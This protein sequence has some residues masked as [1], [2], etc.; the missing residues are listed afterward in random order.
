MRRWVMAVLGLGLAGALAYEAM[1]RSAR[2]PEPAVEHAQP[3]HT[4]AAPI[5]VAPRRGETTPAA[6]PAARPLPAE[7]EPDVAARWASI[8]AMV[9]DGDVAELPKLC[10]AD[11][12]KEPD[13]APAIIH[14][15][16]SLAVQG[17]DADRSLAGKTLSRW[18]REER[19]RDARDAVGNV[20]NIVEALGD[21]GGDEAVTSLVDVLE[22]EED[23]ALQ[24]TAA[25]RLAT[26]G[27]KRA[28][29]AVTRFAERLAR[30]AEPSDAFERELRAEAIK[31][32][33]DAMARLKKESN[34]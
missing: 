19:T 32:A 9:R 29:P 23:L 33:A 28:L 1:P 24:T 14:G 7:L 17:R 8:E 15:V 12:A 21:L 18:L 25:D 27:D 13:A 5:V 20:V 30:A 2:A 10:A 26:L 11:L 16:A 4:S 6:K 3:V 34:E 31:T 22:H